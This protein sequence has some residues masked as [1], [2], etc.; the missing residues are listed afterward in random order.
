LCN[1]APGAANDRFWNY[2]AGWSE[3]GFSEDVAI[4]EVEKQIRK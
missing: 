2:D 3:T 4:S 1:A